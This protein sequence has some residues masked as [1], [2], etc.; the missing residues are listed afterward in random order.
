MRLG[1]RSVRAIVIAAVVLAVLGAPIL[2]RVA[3][4]QAIG[5]RLLASGGVEAR[6]DLVR[7]DLNRAVVGDV[8]LGP[9]AAPSLVADVIEARY[10]PFGI[11]RGQ[12]RALRVEGLEVRLALDG[13]GV[14]M[15][16]LPQSG[17]GGGGGT[18]RGGGRAPDVSIENARLIVETPAGELVAD[19]EVTGGPEQGWRGEAATAGVELRRG[20]AAVALGEAALTMSVADGAL[21]IDASVTLDEVSGVEA[22]AETVTA[23]FRL[24]GVFEDMAR[25]Q[26]L[27]AEGRLSLDAETIAFAPD[28]AERLGRRLALGG[29]LGDLTAAEQAVIT[30]ALARASFAAD[31]AVHATDDR[32]TIAPADEITL[33]AASGAGARLTA[34]SSDALV[35]EGGQGRVSARNLRLEAGVDGGP[36][37]HVVLGAAEL[38][39]EP[40]L[41][42]RFADVSA[43]V[44]REG[45]AVA[46]AFDALEVTV[47]DASGRRLSAGVEDLSLTAPVL[48]GRIEGADGVLDLSYDA[49]GAIVDG[50][51]TLTSARYQ[52]TAPL[53]RFAAATLSAQAAIDAGVATGALEVVDMQG[54]E[55]AR[56]DFRHA[57]AEGAGE[58]AFATPDFAFARRGYQLSDVF[59]VLQGVIVDASGG[60]RASGAMAWSDAGLSGE[61]EISLDDLSFDTRYGR[62]EGL[63]TRFEIADLFGLRTGAPQ[64]VRVA[65]I[66]SGA[67][68]QNGVFSIEL[69]GGAAVRIVDGRFPFAGGELLVEPAEIRWGEPEPGFDLVVEEVDLEAL[70]ALLR[71]PNLYVTGVV[72]GRLPIVARERSV[73]IVGGELISTGAGLIA[74]TG[75]K[76]SEVEARAESIELAFD[77]LENFHYDQ[78]RMTLDGDVAGWLDIGFH[79]DGH[80][81]DVYDGYPFV[82]NL[83]ASAEFAALFLSQRYFNFDLGDV[84]ATPPEEEPGADNGAEP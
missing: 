53:A 59:P 44:R 64:E 28:A 37:A 12:V 27:Q 70:N 32:V 49:A 76:P 67:P 6:F 36:E 21:T 33:T 62:I 52:D 31:L 63:D 47:A 50:S 51:A 43:E 11:T 8:R 30:D 29:V 4:G 60:A 42:A 73:Y 82:F 22:Y 3:I 79:F 5:E 20:D 23:A 34:A 74:Y 41:Y 25:L 81:P 72:N 1:R 83:N 26:G 78:L 16:G 61:A 24:D 66:D 57:L 56:A 54:R 35:F 46:A 39:A 18:P 10:S 75:R 40:D 48:L 2:L 69:P 77:A 14:S 7:L 84:R 68:L 17:A 80:N 58:A 9:V 15:R 65:L 38:R 45:G 19:F 71:P 55:L 13:A